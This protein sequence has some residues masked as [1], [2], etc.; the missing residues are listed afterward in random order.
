MGYFN[1]LKMIKA[2]AERKEPKS[3]LGSQRTVGKLLFELELCQG[4]QPPGLNPV[5]GF[6]TDTAE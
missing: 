1:T 5:S 6:D 4:R 2:R 3:P